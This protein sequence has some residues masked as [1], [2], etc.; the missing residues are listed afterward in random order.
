MSFEEGSSVQVDKKGLLSL[1]TLTAD[2]KKRL[3]PSPV[4]EGIVT[5]GSDEGGGF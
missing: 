4:I 2:Q 5:G 3:L 1:P